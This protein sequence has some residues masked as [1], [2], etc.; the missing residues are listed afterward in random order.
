MIET[1][2]KVLLEKVYLNII[3]AIYWKPTANIILNG[4]KLKTFLLRQGCLLLSLLFNIALEVLDTVIKQEKI[5]KKHP[6]WKRGSKTV[7]ICR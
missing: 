3:K 1:L 7:I 4:R 6:N 2:S 5:S